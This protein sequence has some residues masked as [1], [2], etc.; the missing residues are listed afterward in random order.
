VGTHATSTSTSAVL[1]GLVAFVLA[2]AACSN[3]DTPCTTACDAAS[4]ADGGDA[5]TTSDA[6]ATATGDASNDAGP[7]MWITANGS[8]LERAG[9]A[10]DFRGA[11]SCCGGGYGW[12]LFD[13][14][15]VDYVATKKVNFLH[16]R[17][18]PF[19]TTTPNGETD[20]AATGGGYVESNG[21]ADLSQF[22]AKFWTRLRALVAYARAAGMNVEIDVADGWAVKHCLWGDIPGYSAWDS[23]FNAQGTDACTGAGS[24]PV[25][26]QSIHDAWIRKVVLE[27]GSFDNVIY[28]DGNEIGLVAGYATA[29]STSM[30]AIVRDEESKHGYGRHLFGT[31]SGSAATMQDAAIDYGELHQ[32]LP[33]ASPAACA[34]KPCLVNEYNPNPALDAPTL[35]QRY[36]DARAAGTYFW[37][38]RHD[39]A[40]GVMD[41]TLDLIAAGCP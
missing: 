6:D 36:C 11:I 23:A 7:S 37:Y 22:N 25:V 13:E 31:N 2:F 34:G 8:V 12:P 18:G 20:W 24:G 17:L 28:Q 16:A 3:G 30:E 40:Q 21:K 41:A 29:W 27:T 10:L 33:A 5:A 38:W 15:W 19:L 14:S 26:A 4:P 32:D 39:Q 35:H 1:V 9:V